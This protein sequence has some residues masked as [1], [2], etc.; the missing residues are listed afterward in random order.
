MVRSG[1]IAQEPKH[2]PW[3]KSAG[4]LDPD[5]NIASISEAN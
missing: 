5:G 1:V 3:G 2:E 4:Y